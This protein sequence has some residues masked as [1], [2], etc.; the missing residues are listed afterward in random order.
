MISWFKKWFRNLTNGQVT[1]FYILLVVCGILILWHNPSEGYQRSYKAVKT[2][3]MELALLKLKEYSVS[4]DYSSPY[5]NTYSWENGSIMEYGYFEKNPW[6]WLPDYVSKG[7]DPQAIPKF[8]R[9]P[10]LMLETL[11]GCILAISTAIGMASVLIWL[12]GL[13]KPLPE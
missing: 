11:S 5:P 6:W 4:T 3:S 7:H 13:R 12:T 9:A 1:V 10:L 2:D 8:I